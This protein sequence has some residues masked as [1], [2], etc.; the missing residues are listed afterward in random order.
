[1]SSVFLSRFMPCPGC[2]ASCER[3]AFGE[4]ACDPERSL[5]FRVFQLRDEIAELEHGIEAYLEAPQGRFEVWYA[6]RERRRG[7][8]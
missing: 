2:G 3:S 6:A 7:R 8:R 5:D 4:H 1:M